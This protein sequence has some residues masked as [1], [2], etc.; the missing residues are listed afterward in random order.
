MLSADPCFGFG[1]RQLDSS[2]NGERRRPTLEELSD[3]L[4][5]LGGI[6]HSSEF[7]LSQSWCEDS[8]VKEQLVWSC[9]RL[10]E[11]T[12]RNEKPRP[13]SRTKPRRLVSRKIKLR[14]YIEQGRTENLKLAPSHENACGCV[15]TDCS[16][17]PKPA[18]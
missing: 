18:T 1:K 8:R 10:L 4:E 17:N 14:S 2:F 16:L 11:G 12:P 6:V 5:T 7:C 3:L 9:R 15:P 13:E